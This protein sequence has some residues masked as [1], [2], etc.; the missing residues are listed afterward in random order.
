MPRMALDVIARTPRKRDRT[1]PTIMP[2][3]KIIKFCREVLGQPSLELAAGVIRRW[4]RRVP[5]Q[6]AWRKYL[7]RLSR[8]LKGG[9]AAHPIFR[10]K[11]NMKLPFV[12]FST[13]PL[14]TCPGMGEC[15][16][17][18]YSLRSWRN[19]GPLSRQLQN[20]LLMRF[21]PDLVADAFLSLPENLKVRLYVDGDFE[22][23]AVFGLWMDLLTRRPDLSAYGY[24]KS[25]D[26]IAKAHREGTYVPENYVLNLS[27]GGRKQRTTAEEMLRLP[28]VRG[29]FRA[30]PIDYRHGKV[31]N[32]G[33]ARYSDNNYHRA[34]LRA[35]P[36]TFSCP[37]KCGD[38]HKCGDLNF[39]K[40]ISIGVH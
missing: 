33:F 10:L 40:T 24:S 30:V 8:R 19:A 35:A 9:V 34:V 7:V 3:P 16:R 12:T 21:R 38:C 39:R 25:W 15:G 1:K 23:E 28:F 22:N 26:V 14:F 29:W 13:L 4:A 11:G 31:G 17:F 20:T 37:G 36:G 2:R 18:C 5:A 32:V 6:S 27:S